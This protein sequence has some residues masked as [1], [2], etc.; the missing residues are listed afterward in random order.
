M[1]F[2]LIILAYLAKTTVHIHLVSGFHLFNLHFLSVAS[3]KFKVIL[4]LAHEFV[5]EDSSPCSGLVVL[6]HVK[7]DIVLA[8]FPMVF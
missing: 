8:Y 7:T 3:L 4:F 2:A 5:S 1:L 6:V